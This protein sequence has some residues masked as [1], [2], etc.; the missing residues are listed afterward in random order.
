M[1]RRPLGTSRS[2]RSRVRSVS[3]R[4]KS[5]KYDPAARSIELTAPYGTASGGFSAASSLTI[6]NPPRKSS[7]RQYS[8]SS[9]SCSSSPS[10][11]ATAGGACKAQHAC[12]A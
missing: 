3:L 2:G 4:P 8:H 12:K 7:S 6:R 1:S 5:R 9:S 10:S 11:S